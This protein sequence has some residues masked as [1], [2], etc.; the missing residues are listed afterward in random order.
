MSD[1]LT[2]LIEN[3]GGLL[4][5]VEKRIADTEEVG[6]ALIERADAVEKVRMED[7]GRQRKMLAGESDPHKLRGIEALYLSTAVDRDRARRV[8]RYERDLRLK[9]K[10][11]E[12]ATGEPLI[13]VS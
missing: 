7:M 8:G 4:A 5:K 3:I 10:E 9:R 6:D 1:T 13:V 12:A 2:G 11:R